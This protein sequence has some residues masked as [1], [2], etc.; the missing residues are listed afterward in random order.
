LTTD[1]GKLGLNSTAIDAAAGI[2]SCSSP[3]RF[4]ES[5]AVK[6]FTPVALPP[7][8]ARLAT[9]PTFTGSLP[10]L[11]TMGIVVVGS[12]RGKRWIVATGRDDD[13]HP[14]ADEIDGECWQKL[15]NCGVTRMM[16]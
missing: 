8:R 5:S 2:A 7:G 15:I 10:T 1:G 11:N 16:I 12:L 4:S 6:M 14:A 13:S 3:K 9:S